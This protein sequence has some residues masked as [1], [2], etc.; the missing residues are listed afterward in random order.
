[1]G[2]SD[3]IWSGMAGAFVHR[4]RNDMGLTVPVRAEDRWAMFES[5]YTAPAERGRGL[6]AELCSHAFRWA[7]DARVDW[8]GLHVRDS[9]TRA[10][11]FYLRQGF[12]V[13]ARQ[14][15]PELSVT[16]L[17]MVRPVRK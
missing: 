10:I 8:L 9:N 12:E 3:G 6:A 17:V 14:E 4:E 15:H 11:R 16:T 5:M 1:M 13:A 7:A 2:E